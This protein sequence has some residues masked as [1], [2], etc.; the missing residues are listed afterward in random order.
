VL[1]V[2]QH[3]QKDDFEVGGSKVIF[4]KS[5]QNPYPPYDLKPVMKEQ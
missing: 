2:V 3:R 4:I 5:G 1:I